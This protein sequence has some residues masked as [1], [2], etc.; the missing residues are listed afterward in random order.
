MRRGS[1]HFKVEE[2]KDRGKSFFETLVLTYQTWLQGVTCQKSVIIINVTKARR[3]LYR[4]ETAP[5][6]RIKIQDRNVALRRVH[7]GNVT[8]FSFCIVVDLNDR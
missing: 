4:N 3:F 8:M 7:F 1:L 5:N 2:P 6:D